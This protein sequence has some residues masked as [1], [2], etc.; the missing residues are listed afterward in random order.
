MRV[1]IYARVS[2]EK[3]EKQETIKSQLE[4]LREF[5]K[6][7]GYIIYEEY[8]DEGYSGELLDRPALDKLR[9]DAKRKLFEAVLIHS[10]DRLARLYPLQWI[11]QEELRKYGINI[12]FLNR[13]DNKDTPEDNLLNGIQGLIAEYEKAKIT[14]RTRRGRLYKAKSGILVTSIAP[15][16]Y[17][18]IVGNKA[19]NTIGHYEINPNEAK[20]VRLIFDLF[21]NKHLSIRAVARELTCRNIPPRQGKQWR[22]SSLHRII[23]NETYTGVTYYNKHMMV[24]AN[25]HKNGNKYHRRKKTSLRLKPKDQWIPIGLPANLKIIDKK[26]FD[27]A[28]KQLRR[29]SELSPRNVKYQYLLRGLV[30]CGYCD[31]PYQGTPC[32]GKL[33]YRC[34]N[35]SRTFPLPRECRAPSVKAEILESIVWEKFC[36]AIKNPRLISEQVIKL[37]EKEI[38]NKSSISRDIE[39]IEKELK[40]TENEESRLLDAYRENIISIEQL[41]DQM[42]KIQEKKKQ[43][44]Q[45]RQGLLVKQEGSFS[46][47]SAKKTINDYCRHIESRLEQLG[48]DFGG[49]RYLLTL[50]LNKVV[51]EGKMVRI[52]GI[53]P[54]YSK[55]EQPAFSNIASTSSGCCGLH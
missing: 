45:D 53:I 49:K 18:Y 46:L 23:R 10:P 29:N 21:A 28:Q 32:H 7:N 38:K 41:K 55:E 15:Y 34:G 35:R 39:I 8:I 14:E 27:L 26:T 6:K 43:L 19:T 30:K 33:Y 40:S 4:A 1:A 25:K 5:A 50:A 31:S 9:D 37:K 3:Q 42:A 54:A 24:E 22:S 47:L 12:V 52:K 2:T 13:P 11:V 17:K 48:N 16:G 20:V 51:L 36:E 44:E